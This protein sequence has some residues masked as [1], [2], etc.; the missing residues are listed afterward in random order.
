MNRIE[1]DNL[2][3]EYVQRASLDHGY[4]Y[5]IVNDPRWELRLKWI[6]SD[7]TLPIEFSCDDGQNW[8]KH[9]LST[10]PTWHPSIKY[11]EGRAK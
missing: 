11:R 7:R 5:S 3:E 9:T 2:L 10:P 8:H 6:D 1:S 4:E